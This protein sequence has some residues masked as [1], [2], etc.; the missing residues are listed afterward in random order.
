MELDLALALPNTD[1]IKKLNLNGA[2]A[3]PKKRSFDGDDDGDDGRGNNLE[4]PHG[5]NK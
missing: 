5:L 2:A 4:N 3:R 1:P